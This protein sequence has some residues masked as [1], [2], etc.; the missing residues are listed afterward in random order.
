MIALWLA[1][2]LTRP[3]NNSRLDIERKLTVQPELFL[4]GTEDDVVIATVMAG[5]DGHRGWINY[6]A[7]SPE[8]QRKGLAKQLMADVEVRL[9]AI[10]CPKINLQVRV[11]ND[12]AMAFY[13][14][15]G[16]EEE[17]RV[18]FGKRLISDVQP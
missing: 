8:Y 11:G 2:G 15:Y 6:F 3:W 7:V 16:F 9:K 12:S 1:C 17:E 13:R 10:G 14:A 4:V 5:Y 18:S